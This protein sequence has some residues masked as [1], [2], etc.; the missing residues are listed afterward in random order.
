MSLTRCRYCEQ[1]NPADA[2]F[3]SSCGGALNL[4]PHLASCPRCGTVNPV[5]ATVCCWCSGP[6]AGRR[7]LPRQRS[8]VIV[9]IAALAAVAVLGYY[10]YLKSSYADAPQPLPASSDS[11]V[12]RAPVD[13]GIPG[14]DAAAGGPKSASAEDSAGPT[15]SAA[16]P[17]ETPPAEPLRAAAGQARA[18]RQPIKSQEAKAGEAGSLRPEACTEAAAALGLCA[19]KSVQNREAE[20]A[21]VEA[22]IKR[23]PATGAGNAGRQEPPRPQT[24]TEGIAALGLCT[25][26]STQRRE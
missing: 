5:R 26:K 13:A 1:D 25:Q 2:R 22:A 9:G 15:D 8:R 17:F 24:C 12:L 18:G 16:S 10:T 4:P 6:L 7:S 11:S 3:C 21:A 19:T 23:P 20:T 14:G